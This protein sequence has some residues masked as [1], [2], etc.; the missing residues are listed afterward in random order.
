MS[1]GFIRTAR[2]CRAWVRVSS[3]R[4]EFSELTTRRFPAATRAG[5]IQA[6]RVEARRR[7]HARLDQHRQQRIVEH[8]EAG[9]FRADAT[10]Y[11]EAVQAMTSYKDR[12][13]DVGVWV[14]AFGDR[15]RASI[16]A[17]EIRTLRDRWLIDGPRRH[18]Q[19]ING[20]GQWIDVAAPLA[21]STV[22]HRLRALSNLYTVLDGRR[23][24]NPVQD[25]PEVE[26]SA[27]IPRA[28]DYP[29]IR[30]I[31][32][33]MSDQGRAVKGKGNRLAFSLAK[34]RARVLAWT[35]LTP[36]ELASIK[37]T[38]LY[39]DDKFLIVPARRKGRGAPG[40]IVPLGPEGLAACQD[41]HRLNA[42]GRFG[43]GSVR[44]A[45][46][47]ACR[48]AIGRST[49]LYDLR[50]SF[51]TAVVHATKDVR[52][53]GRL[54]GHTDDRTTSRYATAALLGTL[55]AGVD[56]AFPDKEKPQ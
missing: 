27:E 9:T 4:D 16:A 8:G 50:H 5:A 6:W 38:D 14:V 46:Q 25:V 20:V 12:V 26:E 49:R 37:A 32:A 2:G 33:A 41:F 11:L 34:V 31:L 44:R 28:L 42:Y 21:P 30:A 15:P 48:K 40:R 1:A 7:L 19:R 3:K 53:A 35:G 56:A 17:H 55:R 29:T 43:S 24:V 36:K 10:T 51:I 23:A 45:W 39:W 13:R 18:W 52:L 22:N 47:R 54:A